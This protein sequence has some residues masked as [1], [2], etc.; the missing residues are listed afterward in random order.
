VVNYLYTTEMAPQEQ[1]LPEARPTERM[2]FVDE[3]RI[4]PDGDP[5]YAAAQD[6]PHVC[7]D[8]YVYLGFTYTGED[9]EEYEA[10]EAVPCRRCAEEAR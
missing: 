6:H 5:F 3:V 4:A 8:G 1:P 2:A 10:F 9:G 7:L